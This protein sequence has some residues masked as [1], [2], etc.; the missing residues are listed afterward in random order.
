M[1][2]VATVC[3]LVFILL[4]KFYWLPQSSP[5]KEP[6]PLFPDPNN[7]F[8]ELRS[9][10]DFQKEILDFRP[11]CLHTAFNFSR[12]SGASFPQRQ[13]LR[14]NIKRRLFETLNDTPS[15][16]LDASYVLKCDDPTQQPFLT[17]P[18][19]GGHPTPIRPRQ[20]QHTVGFSKN[21]YPV[22]EP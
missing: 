15:T 13:T 4:C 12:Y 14:Q 8:C 21:S 5:E 6:V 19:V 1:K 3:A 7:A 11:D 17:V 9:L 2:I 20:P 22:H 18:H 16:L 10:T